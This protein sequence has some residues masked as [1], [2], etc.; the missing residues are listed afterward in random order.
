MS[1]C[2]CIYIYIYIGVCVCAWVH[3][4]FSKSG[5]LFCGLLDKGA[6]LLIFIN[7]Q[8]EN[9]ELAGLIYLGLA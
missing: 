8:G 7:S 6:A 9:F 3:G 5:Y 1:V 4:W 2:I